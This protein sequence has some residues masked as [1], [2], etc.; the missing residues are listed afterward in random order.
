LFL[1]LALCGAALAAGQKLV[2]KDGSYQL[3][4]SY[5]RRGDRVR[6][7]SLERNEWE[8]VPAALVDWKATEEAKSK[9]KDEALQRVQE[10]VAADQALEQ[11]NDGPEIAPGLRLPDQDGVFV[12]ENGRV[13]ALPRQEASA[14]IDKGRLA[15]NVLLPVPLLKNRSLVEIPGAHAQVRLEASPTALYANGRA[16]PDSRYALARLKPKG[17]KR[18]VDAIL[19]NLFGRNPRHSGD[20]IELKQEPLGRDLFRLVPSQPLPPGQYAVVE[21]LGNDL[22]LHMWDF[23]V[24]R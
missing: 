14:R 5:E 7:F 18:Q 12:I 8:E 1:T 3:V 15:T 21:F 11:E 17:N 20:Y 13:V 2:M 23:A 10:A 16:R 4:R 19:T 6:Y 24:G 9:A 22:N